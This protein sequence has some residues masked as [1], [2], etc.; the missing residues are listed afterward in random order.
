[1][2]KNYLNKTISLIC[3]LGI[4][5]SL[6]AISFNEPR[7]VIIPQYSNAVYRD[8]NVLDKMYLE[9]K[10]S[11]VFLLELGKRPTYFWNKKKRF[12]LYQKQTLKFDNIFYNGDKSSTFGIDN[13]ILDQGSF[14]SEKMFFDNNSSITIS[15]ETSNLLA[16][17]KDSLYAAFTFGEVSD[18]YEINSLNMKYNLGNPNLEREHII[19]NFFVRNLKF[20]SVKFPSPRM[21]IYNNDNSFV[22]VGTSLDFTLVPANMDNTKSYYGPWTVY[23]SVYPKSSG[24]N[25]CGDK[26]DICHKI[27]EGRGEPD[28]DS[29]LFKCVGRPQNSGYASYDPNYPGGRDYCYDYQVVETEGDLNIYSL[30]NS[31]FYNN[32]QSSY[33]F[34]VEEVY[35]LQNGTATLIEQVPVKTRVG[36]F[37]NSKAIPFGKYTGSGWKLNDVDVSQSIFINGNYVSFFGN[38]TAASEDSSN[39]CFIICNGFLCENNKVY[40][41]NV[42]IR[43]LKGGSE[44]ADVVNLWPESEGRKQDLVIITYTVGFCPAKTVDSEYESNY[45]PSKGKLIEALLIGNGSSWDIPKVCLRRRIKCNQLDETGYNRSYKLLSTDY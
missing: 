4:S 32:N 20:G 35:D 23:G 22:A 25:P 28:T 42:K 9:T 19:N 6:F 2:I 3:F 24:T 26:P 14:F 10:E 13:M 18:K 41:K 15:G 1:M 43:E 30:N 45:D 21:M 17:Y 40:V 38:P 33:E 36:T 37:D 8:L 5:S 16:N 39:P 44:S 12:Y 11:R 34:K 31:K 7:S 29:N 27:I